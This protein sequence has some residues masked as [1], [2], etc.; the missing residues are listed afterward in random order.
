MPR[1]YDQC[2]FV[3]HFFFFVEKLIAVYDYCECFRHPL[4]H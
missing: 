4:T 1:K 3:L 2:F